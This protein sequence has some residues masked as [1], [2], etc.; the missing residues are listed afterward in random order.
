M[1]P[2]LMPVLP[3]KPQERVV[4][5]RR[6]VLRE[7]HAGGARTPTEIA[8]ALKRLDPRY[9]VDIVEHRVRELQELGLV[10]V[11]SA[12]AIG[13]RARTDRRSPGR[14]RSFAALADSWG[15]GVGV[16]VG[17]STIRVAV[18]SPT[19]RIVA[20]VAGS[21]PTQRLP[22]TF[23]SAARLVENALR[24]LPDEIASCVV[25]IVVA[26]SA[27]V[28]RRDGT[29]ASDA[30]ASWGMEPLHELFRAELSGC[31]L[32]IK[33]INDADARAIAEGRFGL[34]RG[35]HSAVVVKVSGGVGSATLRR[36][37]ILDGYRGTAGELGH[38]PVSLDGLN[39][40]PEEANLALLSP[41][42]VCSCGDRESQHLEAYASTTAISRRLE[43]SRDARST[44]MRSPLH[45]SRS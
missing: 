2:V 8:S 39:R 36:G 7:L 25:G 16:E 1:F 20:S 11:A 30:H 17:R 15:F 27:P 26:V 33:M 37:R 18:V 4:L 44:S 5:G 45:G 12:Q 40:P 41:D 9:S 32:P 13:L 35:A 21:R 10:R 22:A 14:P 34:A 6:H 3:R 23:S 31:A 19:G 43:Q 28:D 24:L 42:A 29:V 38:I